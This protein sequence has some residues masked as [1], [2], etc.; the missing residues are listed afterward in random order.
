MLI[1][2]SMRFRTTHS[3]PGDTLVHRGDILTGLSFIA[4]GSVEILSDDNTVMG[5]LGTDFTILAK[6]WIF[7]FQERT[8]FSAKTHFC[9]KKSEN[10]RAVCAHWPTVICIKYYGAHFMGAFKIKI[11]FIFRD[12]LLDVLDMYPEFAENF[13][14]NLHIT[15]NLRD[16]SQ[17]NRKR[18][19]FY[20]IFGKANFRKKNFEFSRLDRHKLL[21]MSSSLNR[22]RY[23]TPAEG[24]ERGE[25]FFFE[26]FEIK[27]KNSDTG[28]PT[29]TRRS[30]TDSV[31]RS[32]SNPLDRIQSAGI[33]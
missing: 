31:S 19:D 32:D 1:F 17:T 18:C 21:R 23:G 25:I 3:P 14:K 10:R 26:K 15:F 16:D 9:T 6:N 28:Q 4:R 2:S 33:L 13:C 12:D 8:T 22:E 24:V 20:N 11:F 30:N 27:E 7:E 5:I 29:T